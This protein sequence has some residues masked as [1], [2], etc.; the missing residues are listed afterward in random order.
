MDVEGYE[1]KIIEGGMKTLSQ[2]RIPLLHEFAPDRYG[3]MM[4]YI[5][6]MQTVYSYFLDVH[7]Y[8]QGDYRI[9]S[10]DEIKSFTKKMKEENHTITDL[11]FF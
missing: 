8:Y 7:D 9:Y 3:D 10:I 5:S 11:F 4:K 2:N 1:A 6:N